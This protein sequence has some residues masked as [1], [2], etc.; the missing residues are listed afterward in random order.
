MSR[1]M[2]WP[3]VG[4]VRGSEACAADSQ[5]REAGAGGPAGAGFGGWSKK[6]RD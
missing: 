1:G 3:M 4:V 2:A 6:I 5:P